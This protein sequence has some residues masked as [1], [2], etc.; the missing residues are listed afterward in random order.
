MVQYIEKHR[1]LADGEAVRKA[2][3]LLHTTVTEDRR[4]IILRTGFAVALVAFTFR[5]LGLQ[6][7][8][9]PQTVFY[10][11]GASII[12]LS[13]G[14]AV[15]FWYYHRTINLMYELARRTAYADPGQED[16]D[17]PGRYWNQRRSRWLAG[18]L[19]FFVGCALYGVAL[20]VRLFCISGHGASC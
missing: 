11:M 6:D 4:Q 1:L 17:L 3:A 7:P 9:T 13:I 12:C 10:L 18:S 16:L 8:S 19:A 15:N 5:D 14:A 20:L 2:L